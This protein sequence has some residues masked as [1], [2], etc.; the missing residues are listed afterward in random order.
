MRD[1]AA[2]VVRAPHLC[3]RL[4]LFWFNS[5]HGDSALAYRSGGEAS[6]GVGDGS[7]T[8]AGEEPL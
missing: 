7:V 5:T 1:K 8:A 4:L 2:A 6:R 3:G